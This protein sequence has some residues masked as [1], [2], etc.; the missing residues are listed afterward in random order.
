[1]DGIGEWNILYKGLFLIR[2][3]SKRTISTSSKFGLLQMVSELYT[4]QYTRVDGV[5]VEPK[6]VV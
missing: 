2:N 4:G 5:R 6:F 1:M 3:E